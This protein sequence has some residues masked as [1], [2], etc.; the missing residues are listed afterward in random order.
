MKLK[1]IA[2]A[3][4]LEDYSL[5]PRNRLDESHVNDLVRSIQSGATLPPIIAD[6]KTL[7]LADGFHRRRAYLK[8]LGEE[9]TVKVELRDYA[10]DAD[11]FI[12]AVALNSTHGRKLDRHDQTRIVLRLREL[13]VPDQTIAIQ[14]HIPPTQVQQLA[15]RVVYAP[16]G[17]VPSKR[18]LEHMRGG[19]MT[20]EQVS[21]MDSVRSG[22]AGRLCIELTKLL[23]AGMVNLSD[24][25]VVERLKQLQNSIGE[26]LKAIAA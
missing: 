1:T 12:D 25:N 9:A 21:V 7:R 15:I 8:A 19:A 10:S 14:L 4:L 16:A 13:N 24:L 17:P 3:T 6:A 18:G 26:A 23:D 20:Q 22:E 5:Y 11:L 2:L